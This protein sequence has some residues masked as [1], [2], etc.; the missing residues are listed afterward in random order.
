MKKFCLSFFAVLTFFIAFS[1]K[2]WKQ[3][4]TISADLAFTKKLQLGLGYQ[5]GYNL[6]NQYQYEFSQGAVY[7]TYDP[8][9]KFALSA[10]GIISS[11]ASGVDDKN[12]G[13]IRA[14]YKIKFGKLIWSNGLQGELHS[15]AETKYRSRMIFMTRLSLKNRL[16]FLRL[17]PSVSYWLYH[18]NGGNPIQYYDPVTKLP[19]IKETAD[20]FHRSRLTI[21]L[22]S[23]IN[24][25]LSVSVYY[26]M[27]REFNMGA[28]NDINVV[29][30]RNGRITRRFDEFNVIGLSLDFQFDLYKKHGNQ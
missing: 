30:P 24:N 2:D 26:K 17:A 8:S 19:S 9:R 5:R 6:S 7:L 1:Q 11:S 12:R 28:G 16:R 15:Q 18:N 20:G 27:Q 21:N 3:W 23:K 29:N 25:Q 13:F 4:N 10:G 14:S 22:N